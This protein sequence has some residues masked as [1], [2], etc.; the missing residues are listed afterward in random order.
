ML[1][2]KVGGRQLDDP[3]FLA[4]LGSVVRPLLGDVLIVHGGGKGTSQL[5][6]R[7]GLTS[8]FVDGQRV[9]DSDTLDC[10]VMGLSGLAKLQ[11]VQAMRRAGL[12]ALGLTGV[13]AGLVMCQKMTHPTED[14]GRVGE[15]VQV[16]A[17]ALLTLTRSGFLV[18]L[19]PL[20]L[21]EK[22]ELYNVNADP[23]AGAVAAALG[24]EALIFVTDVAG[25]LQNGQVLERLGP[26]EFRR[27][28]ASG[29]IG[30]GMLPKLQACFSAL[31]QG[32]K[33]V[34]ITNL[35]G[36]S[37]RTGTWIVDE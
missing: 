1:V 9:T 3:D 13:D 6:S 24:A 36:L 20:C 15:P 28:Q 11:I 35:D 19:S 14:L 27:L 5:S 12:P 10:A 17:Q 18:C 37:Q 21:D 4:G 26:S 30:P 2:L 25:V 34:L 31:E 16:N 7:L 23:V 8:R 22:G 33:Q 32:L 29:D